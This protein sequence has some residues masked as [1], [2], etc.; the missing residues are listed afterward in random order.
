M[1]CFLEKSRL[2]AALIPVGMLAASAGAD[3][4]VYDTIGDTASNPNQFDFYPSI[5]GS[6][7]GFADP[8]MTGNRAGGYDLA[9]VSIGVRS[10]T[11]GAGESAVPLSMYIY[12][13]DPENTLGI[14]NYKPYQAIA[15]LGTVNA[16]GPS[17]YSF[18]AT[19]VH[20]DANTNYAVAVFRGTSLE[21]TSA[22]SGTI[23][24][25]H[26]EPPGPVNPLVTNTDTGLLWT[27]NDL[28]SSSMSRDWGSIDFGSTEDSG[29]FWL[30]ETDTGGFA[31]RHSFAGY[32]ELEITVVPEP[33]SLAV[34]GMLGLI[35][36]GRRRRY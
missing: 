19:G 6:S 3:T 17:V 21:D 1:N 32:L 26:A 20:L 35:A 11:P 25:Q 13:I 12:N 34:M 27:G 8:F 16:D 28:F 14:S 22:A 31:R 4:T 5:D 15:S 29:F 9:Q 23:T 30:G 2:I 33:S 24:L 10:V 7:I 36:I 18:D